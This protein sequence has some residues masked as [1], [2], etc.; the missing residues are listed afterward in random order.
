M[1]LSGVLPFLAAL[2]KQTPDF[3]GMESD[4]SITAP[5][6]PGAQPPPNLNAIPPPSPEQ[7][8]QDLSDI[9]TQTGGEKAPK[10]QETKG[11]LLM[12]LLQG[13]L[14]GGL[15]GLAANAQT[16]AQTGRNAG[17]GGGFAGAEQMP[18]LQAQRAQQLQ[19]GQAQIN[20]LKQQAQ[21]INVPGYGSMPAGLA[22]VLF[23]SLIRGNAT[24]TAAQIGSQG[25]QGA[26][27]IGANARIQAAQMGLGPVADVPQDLQDQFGLPAKLPLKMLNQAESAA[28]K[29]LT[30]VSGADDSFAVNKQTGQK[31]ALGVGSGRIA[32]TLARPVQVA[33]PNNPGNV[34]YESA[35]K[36]M[37]TGA[38]APSSAATS[39][40]KSEA[41]SE[42]PTKIGDQKVAFN[43]M[44]QHA[45]LLR[46]AAA[47]LN[48]GDVQAL[49]GLKNS[50]KNQFGY[51]GPITAEAIADAYKGEV[52]NVINKG[53]ITDAGNEKVAHTLDPAH[54]N[55]QTIDSV[56]GA[57]QSLAQSKLNMLNQ[58]ANVAKGV[59][60]QKL[61][62]GQEVTIGGKKMKVTS[63]HADG[64][65]D[66][67]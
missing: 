12:R 61:Q 24:T 56:L 15:N 18:F 59:P 46:Q 36:A 23:P 33:D 32:A 21:E 58:Q 65:F 34:T 67:Q 13:G 38:M 28:N 37:S 35:G 31:R 30:V 11:H 3:S 54:Q 53:H 10:F 66:A 52:S 5:P 17:F 26:A 44:I 48:N 62:L 14:Q 8:Q 40:A 39:A 20:L 49:A 47:A 50:F 45:Q 22:K 63:I 9:G 29:P 64:S 27:Q 6:D 57:Y 51:S 4:N 7:Q 41:K 43:T 55:Y 25:R 42:V 16:Y 2:K 19:M 60:Q 1:G